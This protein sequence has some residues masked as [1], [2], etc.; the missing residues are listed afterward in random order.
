MRTLPDR[1]LEM[2]ATEAAQSQAGQNET[3]EP[4]LGVFRV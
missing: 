4:T 2:L 3:S 1:K